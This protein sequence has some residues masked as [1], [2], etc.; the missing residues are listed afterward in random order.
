MQVR[1]AGVFLGFLGLLPDHHP[2]PPPPVLLKKPGR[3][4][5]ASP[6]PHFCVIYQPTGSPPALTSPQKVHTW[7]IHGVHPH[8]VLTFTDFHNQAEDF[9]ACTSS[10]R[11]DASSMLHLSQQGCVWA[12]LTIFHNCSVPSLRLWTPLSYMMSWPFMALSHPLHLN[13][14]FGFMRSSIPRPFTR[15]TPSLGLFFLLKV[16]PPLRTCSFHHM[17]YSLHLPSLPFHHAAFLACK[18]LYSESPP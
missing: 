14:C 9:S 10:A 1:R 15:I 16:R 8:T 12:S 6:P 2:P 7:L 5:V 11:V 17:P 4:L 3:L 13:L 18:Y